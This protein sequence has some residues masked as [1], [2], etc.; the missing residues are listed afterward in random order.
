MIKL[1]DFKNYK[2]LL[3]SEL[4]NKPFRSR[5][6]FEA[7]ESNKFYKDVVSYISQLNSDLSSDSLNTMFLDIREKTEYYYNKSLKATNFSLKLD[8]SLRSLAY[9][10]LLESIDEHSNFSNNVIDI[11]KEHYPKNYLDV[12]SDVDKNYKTVYFTNKKISISTSNSYNDDF[13][14]KYIVLKYWQDEQHLFYSKKYGKYIKKLEYKY[15]NDYNLSSFDVEHYTLRKRLFN[16]LSNQKILD[17]DMCSILTELY[18]KKYVIKYIG[19]KMY[20]L[21]VLN[22]CGIKIPYTVVIPTDVDVNIRDL[23]KI[24]TKYSKYSVRS[25]ADVEDGSVNSFAGMFDSYLNVNNNELL[26]SISK[27]KDSVNNKRLLEYIKHNNL[28]MPKMAVVVQSFKEPS[29]AG[30]WIGNNTD[31]GILEWV[32]G[33]GEKLVSGT[34]TPVSENWTDEVKKEYLKLNDEYIGETMINY[35]KILNTNADFEWMILNKKLVMLQYRPV[36]KEIVFNHYDEEIK[37]DECLGIPSS[38]GKIIATGQFL[39]S[40][41]QNINESSILLAMSTDPDWL[42]QLIKAKA[43]IT[44]YGGFLCHTAIVCREL[45]IPCVVGVGEKN[46]KMLDGKKISVN[47][48]VGLIKIMKGGDHND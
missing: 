21:S 30:V 6:L 4:I 24:S 35:Q 10:Y 17:V 44:A 38:P 15:C 43:A 34:S 7:L 18:I 20:G 46:I 33:N 47:G 2:Q 48:N 37:D 23:K 8:Y 39:S 45:G 22:S 42:P 16:K 12:I 11:I 31:S 27:V 19:G 41:D 26:N 32:K 36:T 9:F 40:P 3:E 1:V 25:S 14:N 28:P 13:V 5:M 29:Y